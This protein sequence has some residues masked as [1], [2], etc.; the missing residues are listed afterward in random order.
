MPFFK[1]RPEAGGQPL[2]R[3]E[4]TL[5]TTATRYRLD[6]WLGDDL[7]ECHPAFVVTDPLKIALEGLHD[8]RGYRF[9]EASLEPSPFLRQK[10][11]MLDLPRFWTLEVDGVAGQS[12][13]GLST[14]GSL[15]VSGRVL[16]VLVL[17][18]LE[19]ADIQ[20]WPSRPGAA[21]AA[22]GRRR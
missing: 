3:A 17:H 22:E 1:L 13:M 11:P 4:R 9:G 14:E 19:R 7:I 16:G 6:W 21:I 8:G 10:R 12:D 18:Q 5:G 15:I 20:Q 2:P